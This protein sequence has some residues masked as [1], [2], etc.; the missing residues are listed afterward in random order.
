MAAVLTKGTWV[1]IADG[2]KALFLENVIDDAEPYLRVIDKE[3]QSN[4]PTR[5]QGTHR[6]GRMAGGG[7]TP[8]SAFDDTDWHALAKERFAK[9]LSD[10]LYKSAHAGAF[11]RLVVVAS[12]QV[13]GDLRRDLHKE[14]QARIVAEIPKL[15]TNHPLSAIDRIVRAEVR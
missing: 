9:D 4:P 14:V 15:L 1:L 10:M 11:E 13:L 12:R 2:E 3:E 8:R 7:G 5:E 6:P